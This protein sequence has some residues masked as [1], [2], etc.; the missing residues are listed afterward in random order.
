MGLVLSGR[1]LVE[2]SDAWGNDSVLGAAGEGEVFAEAYACA[3]GEPLLVNVTASEES[4]V[5]LLDAGRLL[6]PCE[7]VCSGHAL[8]LRRLL[9]LCARK[10]LQLSQRAL[11]T[12]PKTI[13]GRLMS[14]LSECAVRSGSSSF[15]I[16]YDRRQLAGYLG[17]QFGPD[18]ADIM[19]IA[20]AP[21]FRGQGTAKALIAAMTDILQTK[22]LRWLTLEVRPSN[23]QAV[24]LYKAMGFREV[25]RRPRYY[26]KP[27]EDALLMTLFFEE[28]THADPGN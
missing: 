15:D 23:T 9:A 6:S 7:S 28:E 24:G 18:G 21:E 5:L 16:P 8:L 27:T 4:T 20:T 22:H 17:V 26:K 1:V 12:A 10:N 3:P 13:R 11:H 2:L 14:Y 25:G 19:T